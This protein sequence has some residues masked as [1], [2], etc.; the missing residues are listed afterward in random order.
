MPYDLFYM[1]KV[2]NKEED[3]YREQT[4]GFQSGGGV[5][6]GIEWV[7]GAKGRNFQL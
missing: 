3:W 7:K 4:S 5:F 6:S 2:K 1:R